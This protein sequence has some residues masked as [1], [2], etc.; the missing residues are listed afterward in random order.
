MLARLLPLVIRADASPEIGSG[1][2]IRPLSLADE[3]IAQGGTVHFVTNRYG[4]NVLAT[5]RPEFAEAALAIQPSDTAP[6]PDFR[7]LLQQAPTW[8]VLDGYHFGP[9]YQQAVRGAAGY[10]AVVDDRT[11]HPSY[12]GHILLNQNVHAETFEYPADSGIVLRG[13]RF[14][15]IRRAFQPEQYPPRVFPA[16]A[17]KIL[18]TFGGTDPVNGCAR[19]LR[20]LTALGRSDLQVRILQGVLAGK[21]DTLIRILERAPFR[22]E[23][24]PPSRDMASL[25]VWADL[26]VC[27]AGVTCLEAAALG[28][29]ML[30]ATIADNQAGIAETLAKQGA[31]IDMGD[32]RMPESTGTVPDL[33]TICDS[34]PRRRNLSMQSRALVDT[35]GP[36]RM[37]E[38]LRFLD[39]SSI[40]DV[41]D[42]AP[43]TPSDCLEVWRLANEPS[44]RRSAFS[45]APIP[46]DT[47]RAWF[48]T[49][50]RRKE[51]LMYILRI[52][53]ALAGLVR[54][55]RH[56]DAVAVDIAVSPGFRGRA[57]GSRLLERTMPTVSRQLGISRILATV[58]SGN[59]ASQRMFDKAGFAITARETRGSEPVVLFEKEAS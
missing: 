31:C 28:L 53:G 29:P 42:I 57:L 7:D 56:G 2:I 32:F 4:K 51:S 30:T 1:H 25:M 14:A 19:I 16:R 58:K 33:G 47:H 17:E 21:T 12:H 18:I 3:W 49:R 52:G 39:G 44:V 24:L 20:M 46:L 36:E 35:G 6:E 9:D 59:T 8:V 41:L 48:A 38:I 27:A 15:L 54:Y 13:P 26:L 37:V 43:A 10:L 11:H 22:W 40:P 50:L 55:D 5:L 23:I 34:A 45:S